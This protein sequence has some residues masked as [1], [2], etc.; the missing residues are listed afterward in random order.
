MFVN[1]TM[2]DDAL[3]KEYAS[4]WIRRRL[5]PP[6]N[7][8]MVI[9]LF[10]IGCLLLRYGIDL[11]VLHIGFLSL[12]VAIAVAIITCINLHIMVKTAKDRNRL[13]PAGKGR[14]TEFTDENCVV[15]GNDKEH[16]LEIP[17]SSIKDH[18][19]S[20]NYFYVLFPGMVV[21]ALSKSGFSV[22]SPDQFRDFIVRFPRSRGARAVVSG[23]GL[24]VIV[25]ADL[26]LLVQAIQTYRV[27]GWLLPR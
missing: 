18:W 16:R 13:F 1:T 7:L 19:E 9:A 26:I 17:L 21:A 25:I 20:R 24:T 11:S 10:I 27:V 4:S 3:I 14:Q 6:Y 23:V 8:M 5:L 15:N 22:G 12:M 2:L